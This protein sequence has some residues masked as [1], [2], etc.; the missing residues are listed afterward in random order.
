METSL[1][2]PVPEAQRL[3]GRWRDLL[4]P[5][6]DQGIPA[7]ITLAAPFLPLSGITEEVLLRLR[8]LAAGHARPPKSLAALAGPT[9][10]S[11]NSP[12]LSSPTSREISLR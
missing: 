4:D 6:A 11:S 7:H 3:V 12:G 9:P 8:I 10:G 2:A 1:I 5:W